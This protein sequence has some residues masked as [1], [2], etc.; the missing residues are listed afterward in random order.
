VAAGD[1][2]FAHARRRR[3]RLTLE[4]VNALQA[5]RFIFTMDD[6]NNNWIIERELDFRVASHGSL[7]ISDREASNWIQEYIE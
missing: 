3:G 5:K 1:P 7:V 6:A 2:Q 4:S